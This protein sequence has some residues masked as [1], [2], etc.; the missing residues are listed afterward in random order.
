MCVCVC[1]CLC[2]CVCACSRKHTRARQRAHAR[3]CIIFSVKNKTAKIS[4]EFLFGLKYQHDLIYRLTMQGT[5]NS[6]SMS[7]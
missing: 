6:T 2:V 7:I 3:V 4:I 5:Q 1:V